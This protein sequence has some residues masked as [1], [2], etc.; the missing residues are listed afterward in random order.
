MLLAADVGTRTEGGH[1]VLL[2]DL[3]R[4]ELHGTGVHIQ[5]N[6]GP[7]GSCEPDATTPIPAPPRAAVARSASM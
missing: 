7:L 5:H 6:D 4:A 3:L 1:T 2:G